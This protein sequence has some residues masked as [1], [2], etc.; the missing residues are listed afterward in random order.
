M[1]S[2]MMYDAG[3]VDTLS[4]QN[5][6]L[7][8][9]LKRSQEEVDA[10]KQIIRELKSTTEEMQ[11]HTELL[12][13]RQADLIKDI[14]FKASHIQSQDQ[15]IAKFKKRLD[16]SESERKKSDN[17]CRDYISRLETM[18]SEFSKLANTCERLKQEYF[19]MKSR[20]EEVNAN[21]ER[22]CQDLRVKTKT[23]A[24]LEK[25]LQSS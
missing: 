25:R 11:S 10:Y 21:Y 4:R 18:T 13:A 16:A 2:D 12:A 8:I 6:A 7:E 15:L 3:T 5:A 17:N 9:E 19:T 1:V 20:V 24:H 23:V 22:V 14:D